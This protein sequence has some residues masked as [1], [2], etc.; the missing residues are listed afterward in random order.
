MAAFPARN[1]SGHPLLHTLRTS[2]QPGGLRQ[3][4]QGPTPRGRREVWI[5]RS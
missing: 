4:D 3:I 1:Q 2:P 5:G